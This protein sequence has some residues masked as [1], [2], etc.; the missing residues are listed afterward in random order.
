MER[1]LKN[2]RNL[3]QWYE[4]RVES[5]QKR[6][7]MLDKGMVALVSFSRKGQFRTVLLPYFRF[8]CLI[9]FEFIITQVGHTSILFST[10]VS[11]KNRCYFWGIFN[12]IWIFQ[13]EIDKI[14][15]LTFRRHVLCVLLWYKMENSSNKVKDLLDNKSIY[16]DY[17]LKIWIF[18]I[19]T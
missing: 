9:N 5:L 11:L 4:D 15:F 6:R 2:T 12:R 19:C 14:Q 7:R 18:R 8:I 13:L 3:L 10:C 17:H 16:R 1:G